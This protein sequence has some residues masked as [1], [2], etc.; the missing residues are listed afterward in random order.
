MSIV[1]LITKSIEENGML[2]ENFELPGE[3]DTEGVKF[4]AGAM[5]GICMYH[6]GH[7]PLSDADK[8]R[9][10]ELIL[11]AGKSE[12]AE[13]EKGF[14]QFCKDHRAITIIDEL[15]ECV[16][17]NKDKLDPNVMFEFA[18]NMFLQSSDMECVKI[19]LSILELFNTQGD[20]E[21]ETAIKTIALFDEFTIFSVFLM[22]KW[23]TAEKDILECAKRVHGWGRIH[24][25]DYIE[26]TENE[27][28]EWL[29]FNGIDND[30]MPAYSAWNVFIKADVPALIRRGNLSLEE[31]HAVLKITEALMDEGPVPGLSNM[32]N[33]EVFLNDVLFRAEGNYQFTEDD[34]KIINDIRNY[35]TSSEMEDI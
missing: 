33:P 31:M 22:R 18:N 15:Q 16:I 12:F 17:D 28:K 10:E 2:P 11:L 35:M 5:D 26:P 8:K 24:C 4:A 13:A 27:T 23:S 34:L 20:R 32:D 3:D 6:M 30:V 25:T 21:L 19:G 1:E 7:N 9:L 29:L 14:V